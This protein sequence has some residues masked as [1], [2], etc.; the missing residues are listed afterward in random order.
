MT[1]AVIAA[2]GGAAAV[3]AA[4]LML[5]VSLAVGDDEAAG[6]STPGVV[7]SP[8]GTSATTGVAG[9]SADQLNNAAVIVAVGKQIG[10]PQR[11][12]VIAVAT[13]MQESGL[14]NLS[15]GDRDSVGLF[16]QRLSQ[17]WGSAAEIRDP[18]LAARSFYTHLLHISDWQTKPLTVV[19]QAVQRSAFPDAYA[20]WEQRADEVVG[21]V[22]GIPCSTTA[23]ASSA[24]VQVV[25]ARASA[26]L[27]VPYAWGG[28]NAGGPT[29]GVGSSA[30]VV[31][32]DCSGLMVYAFAA[33]GIT[34]PHQTQA[35]WQ[36][37]APPITNPSQ[38]TPGDMVLLSSNGQPSGIHHVGLYLGNGT[39]IDAPEAGQSVRIEHNIWTD[40]YWRTQFVGAVRALR[41]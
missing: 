13:A 24:A 33:A 34:V 32:F 37:F 19:A 1:A 28:G 25:I 20:R 21:L 31:G 17:G 10:V 18:S 29:S 11:G 35:I 7:C 23:A 16:Q 30:S 22:E 26:Q 4:G 41:T 6:A 36:Q 15:G 40:P 5:V 2:G 3:G 12:W 14:R 27:G 39:V 9:F 38:V 8:P